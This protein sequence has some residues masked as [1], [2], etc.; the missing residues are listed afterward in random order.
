MKRHRSVEQ[1]RQPR[2]KPYL[3]GQLIFDKGG[4]SIKWSKKSFFNKW[5]WEIWTGTYRKNE[6]RPPTYNTH[7]DKLKGLRIN[8]LSVKSFYI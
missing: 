5:C 7:K 1:N 6:T 2:H 3:Y 8:D 4:R